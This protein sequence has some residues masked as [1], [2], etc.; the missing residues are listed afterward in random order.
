[1]STQTSVDKY[2]AP[3]GTNLPVD[4]RFFPNFLNG[5]EQRIL[6]LS[7]LNKLDDADSRV[8]RRRRKG[9]LTNPELQILSHLFLPDEFYDF[10]EVVTISPLHQSVDEGFNSSS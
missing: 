7:A 2:V 4:F 6:L 1:M 10:E 8:A 9:N 3:S 5:E